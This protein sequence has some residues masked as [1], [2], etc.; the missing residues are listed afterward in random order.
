MW[1]L[2]KKGKDL[3][4][5]YN[6]FEDK[7]NVIPL[8][9]NITEL[10]KKNQTHISNEILDY[11]KKNKEYYFYPAQYWSHKNHYY[12]LCALQLLKK[13]YNQSIQFVFTGHKKNNY[14]FL[15][16]KMNEFG[17]DNQIT[18]FEY[19]NDEDIKSLYKNCKGVVMPSL[20]GYSSLPLYE[21]FYFKKPIFYTKDLLDVSLKKY[22]NEINIED[23]ENLVNEFMNFEKNAKDIDLKVNLAKS[24][25]NN[26]L[27]KDQISSKYLEFFNK[28]KNLTNIYK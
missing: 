26:N 25:F 24:F 8:T 6:C 15:V 4:K 5:Y 27:S 20:V 19:L 1:I 17:L 16:N 13:K 12:I 7:I 22:V 23:P 3:I 11:I 18:F 14:N 9:T 2:K 28:I 10:E 21:A